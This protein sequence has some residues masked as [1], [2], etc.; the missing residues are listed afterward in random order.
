VNELLT[1]AL[2][3][4]APILSGGG[5]WAYLSARQKTKVSIASSQTDLVAALNAQTKM[6]LSESAKDRRD[7]KRVVA[8][9]GAQLSRVVKE[10]ADCHTQHAE[11]RVT[12][13]SL[14]RQIDILASEGKVYEPS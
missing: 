4:A 2:A 3:L 13:E 1:A 7:L 8:R 14:Q 5:V 12:V 11:C 6:L 10:V 9:Q